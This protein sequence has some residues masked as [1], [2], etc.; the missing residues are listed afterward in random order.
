MAKKYYWL[1]LQDSFFNSREIKKLRSI[2]GGDTFTIIYLKMQL[3]SIKHDGIICFEGTENDLSEQLSIEL[4]EDIEN[5]KLT[6]N[7]LFNNRLLEQIECDEYLLNKVPELIGKETDAAERMRKLREKRN[8]VT[9][10]LQDV[11]QRRE[12]KEKEKIK[13]KDISDFFEDV[14]KL[15]PIKKGKGSVSDTQKKKLYSIG[16]EEM[17]RAIERYSQDNKDTDKRYWKHGST[18]F[19]SGYIDYLDKNYEDKPCEEEQK[20][21]ESEYDYDNFYVN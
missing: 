20:G 17:T 15:Y 6:L 16:L 7:F 18:F 8:N 11:T 19:N 10:L 14:W 2:A 1:K 9:P 4:D 5:I 13:K 12:E 21:E 3:H